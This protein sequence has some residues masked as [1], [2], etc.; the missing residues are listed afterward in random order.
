MSSSHMKITLESSKLQSESHK[1]VLSLL[2][3]K[4]LISSHLSNQKEITEKAKWST[5]QDIKRLHKMA[6][7]EAI[8]TRT[9][10]MQ[11]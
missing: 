1:N 11:N 10:V 4:D 9:R 6:I 3:E 5:K 8:A 2:T 7:E